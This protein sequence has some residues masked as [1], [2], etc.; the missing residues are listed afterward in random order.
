M[1][2]HA[3]YQ[4]E[5]DDNN[6]KT[7][8]HEYLNVIWDLGDIPQAQADNY[9][10]QPFKNPHTDPAKWHDGYYQKF[11]FLHNPQRMSYTHGNSV[12][13]ANEIG[14]IRAYEQ[15][16][17]VLARLMNW[18]DKAWNEKKQ[19]V[20]ISTRGNPAKYDI[21]GWQTGYANWP[22]SGTVLYRGIA[23]DHTDHKG[24]LSYTVDFATETGKGEI[25]ELLPGKSISLETS[26]NNGGYLTGA[27]KVDGKDAYPNPKGGADL[28]GATYNVHFYG[29][30]AEEIAGY[31]EAA[32][33]QVAGFAGQQQ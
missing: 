27:V 4:Q 11:Y 5:L 9:M 31:V 28:T 15:Y 6:I 19:T 22:K 30:R 12:Q 7:L 18:T 20:Y 33:K 32:S 26:R 17:S 29:P 14:K 25:T 10:M 2:P 23:M 21:Y 24:K 13:Q 8:H 1:D 3:E 16:Y